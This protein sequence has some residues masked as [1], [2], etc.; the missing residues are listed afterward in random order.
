MYGGE[1]LLVGI[2]THQGYRDDF[3]FFSVPTGFALRN[4]HY[5]PLINVHDDNLI[6]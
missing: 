3:Q 5:Q 4:H 6:S 1:V 2:I